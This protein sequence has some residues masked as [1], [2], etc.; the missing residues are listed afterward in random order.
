MLSNAIPI[1]DSILSISSCTTYAWTAWGVSAF[2]W[3]HMNK[4]SYFAGWKQR[5]FFVLNVCI[6]LL[7]LFM[8][9]AGLWS[10]ISELMDHFDKGT[11]VRGSFDC[12]NNASF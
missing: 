12:G 8:N 1:F 3:F 7:T 2:F 11:G 9:S 6:I 5:G 4:G 10:A